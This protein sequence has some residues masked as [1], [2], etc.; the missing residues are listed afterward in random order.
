MIVLEFPPRE[1]LSSQVS[2]ESRYGMKTFLLRDPELVIALEASAK[3]EITE[4]RV[5]KD[6]LM[7]APSFK[8]FP[9]APGYGDK[10]IYI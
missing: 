7:W 5:T 4:P 8:R 10:N 3:A 1:S 6:L 9:V 2:V